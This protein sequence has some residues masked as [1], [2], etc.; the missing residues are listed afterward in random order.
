MFTFDDFFACLM[1]LV[2]AIAISGFV[3]AVVRKLII[4]WRD[5]NGNGFIDGDE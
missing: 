5:T 1:A 2:Y 4:A 3:V